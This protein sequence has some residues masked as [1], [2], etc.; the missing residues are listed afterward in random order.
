MSGAEAYSVAKSGK[1]KLKNESSSSHKKHKK[2][3][4]RKSDVVK[5]EKLEDEL[6]HAGS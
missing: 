4:K 2:S 6:N 1:L 5:D 3:K